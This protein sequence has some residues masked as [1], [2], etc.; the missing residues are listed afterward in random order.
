MTWFDRL[1]NF[2]QRWL[3]RPPQEEFADLEAAGF[4][5]VYYMGQDG[6]HR[7]CLDQV[8]WWVAEEGRCWRFKAPVYDSEAWPC[9]AGALLGSVYRIDQL[10]LQYALLE[11]GSCWLSD[12]SLV[13][14]PCEVGP[15]LT[16]LAPYQDDWE[17]AA[18]HFGLGTIR[19]VR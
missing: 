11:D 2:I 10:P 16:Q 14:H 17:L 5:R 3:D 18:R 1:K 19:R 4:Q 6:Q 12:Q 7:T 13:L 9:L 8:G 15:L